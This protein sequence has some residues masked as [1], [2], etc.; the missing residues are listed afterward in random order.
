MI[1]IESTDGKH[2]GESIEAVNSIITFEDGEVMQVTGTRDDGEGIT[3]LYNSNY[4]IRVRR[5]NG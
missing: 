5:E 3:L 1:V 2:I 4:Q